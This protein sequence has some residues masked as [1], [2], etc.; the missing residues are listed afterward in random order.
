MFYY[1]NYSNYNCCGQY[2]S[3]LLRFYF[4]IYLMKQKGPLIFFQQ[5][6]NKQNFVVVFVVVAFFKQQQ[7]DFTIETNK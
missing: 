6:I 5:N 3:T 2:K 4:S 1:Y 7:K